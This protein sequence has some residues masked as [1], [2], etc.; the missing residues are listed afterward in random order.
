MN[1]SSST[2]SPCNENVLRF[3]SMSSY[4]QWFHAKRVD[5]GLLSRLI[6][7][8]CLK[9][10]HLQDWRAFVSGLSAL[11][12]SPLQTIEH[13]EHSA[14]TYNVRMALVRVCEHQCRP[15]D[16]LRFAAWCLWKQYPSR[17][18]LHSD[19]IK[20]FCGKCHISLDRMLAYL[21]QHSREPSFFTSPAI[22]KAED[23]VRR[24]LVGARPLGVQ[25][26]P[27]P[28]LDTVQNS[29]VA[30]V[31]EGT[32]AS[33][34]VGGAGVGKTT[35][36]ASLVEQASATCSVVC[37][38]YT[39]KAR[40]VMAA[41]MMKSSSFSSATNNIRI[42]TIH[43]FIGTA[44]QAASASSTSSSATT[45][46]NKAKYTSG[47]IT[48]FFRPVVA[49]ATDTRATDLGHGTRRRACLYVLDEASM[50]DLQLLADLAEVIMNADENYQ[51]CFVGDDGQLPPM[52]RGE[53]FRQLTRM[54]HPHPDLQEDGLP[55]NDAIHVHRLMT[56]YRT[57]SRALFDGC[58]AL[59][60]GVLRLGADNDSSW[61]VRT[62]A[63]DKDVYTELYK[64]IKTC[65]CPEETQYIA[66]QNKDV[67]K[68]NE[69]VQQHLVES[70][71]LQ[72]R[73]SWQPYGQKQQQFYEGDKVVYVG[74]NIAKQKQSGGRELT[75]AMT[76]VVTQAS[77]TSMTV[78]WENDLAT[79]I[80]NGAKSVPA[81]KDVQ[82]AYCV[83]VHKSQGSEHDVVVVPCLEVEKMK[84]L[85]DRRWLYTAATR[86]KRRAVII[87]TADL[88][89]FVSKAVADIPLNSLWSQL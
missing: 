43:S 27:S 17:V 5:V 42:S 72:S 51:L 4:P 21:I 88:S 63:S 55:L 83:T 12:R 30:S 89:S 50:I 69:L 67:R 6:D 48:S 52:S 73:D 39:H 2:S 80:I 32:G 25:H 64:M 9:M 87:A 54:T 3:F 23:D 47:K 1:M 70:G 31:L 14:H 18:Y 11:A 19:A 68:I 24:F 74:E 13:G 58:Q 66:W 59:R 60:S 41:K 85:L 61:E 46:L 7:D 56:C 86:A 33:V 49:T 71:V 8:G 26:M 53:V 82:L 84:L 37:M 77:S 62:V 38:A 16:E 81:A 45:V 44:K 79:T 29:I 78:I 35:T 20:G 36:I 76:G 40:R 10:A 65:A 22:K 75:N 15:N 57:S 28:Q 34:I